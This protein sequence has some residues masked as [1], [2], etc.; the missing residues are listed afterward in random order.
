MQAIADGCICLVCNDSWAY[1]D[2]SESVCK[3]CATLKYESVVMVAL[4]VLVLAA[5]VQCGLVGRAHREELAR[6]ANINRSLSQKQLIM[7]SADAADE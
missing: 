6:L 2:S 1:Y 4:A 7:A 5:I 3:G